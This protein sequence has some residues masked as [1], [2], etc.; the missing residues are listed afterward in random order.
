VSL[1]LSYIYIAWNINKHFAKE[2]KG[3]GI[4]IKAIFV[5]F[6]LSFFSRAIVYSLET[7]KVIDDNGAVFYT[8][9]F[10]WDVLPLCCIMWYHLHAFKDEKKEQEEPEID[11]TR[12]SY[13]SSSSKTSCAGPT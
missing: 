5:V 2:L 9:Y 13:A 11:W 4:K 1:I 8:M 10:F 12:A 3:E 7:L 6:A